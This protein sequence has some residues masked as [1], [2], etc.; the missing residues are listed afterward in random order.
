MNACPSG[1]VLVRRVRR[2]HT[3][4]IRC[5]D[6][7]GTLNDGWATRL[8]TIVGKF[9][10]GV[11][12]GRAQSHREV[13]AVMSMKAVS[14]SL[15]LILS[16]KLSAQ[17]THSTVPAAPPPI[18]HKAHPTAKLPAGAAKQAP[19]QTSESAPSD[20]APTSIRYF[21]FSTHP[22][23]R[24]VYVS[25]VFERPDAGSDADNIMVYQLAKDDFQIYLADKYKY[26]EVPGLVD[27]EY[28]STVTANSAAALAAKKRRIVSQAAAAKKQVVE[29]RWK[30]TE[31][32]PDDDDPIGS[33]GFITPPSR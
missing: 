16:L 22:K 13:D 5:A 17:Q 32:Q 4:L 15:L 20:A 2:E 23:Q 6:E 28:M 12:W 10:V 9:S 33:G 30:G 29:T 31:T 26:S 27:C 14:T 18:T 3:P 7:W 21:C 8:P 25:D 1:S 19:A 24:V 11:I